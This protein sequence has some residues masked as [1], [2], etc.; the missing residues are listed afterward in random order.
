MV[1][2]IHRNEVDFLALG[3]AS[4]AN[5]Q[6]PVDQPSE[7]SPSASATKADPKLHADAIRLVEASGPNNTFRII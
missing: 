1:A 6:S 3:A 7:P 4:L 5:A 2:I